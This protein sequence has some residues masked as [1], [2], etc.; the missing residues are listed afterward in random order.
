MLG[1]ELIHV[2]LPGR[3]GNRP[4]EIGEKAM[5]RVM[6]ETSRD[7]FNLRQP[8]VG[9]RLIRVRCG[10]LAPLVAVAVWKDQSVSFA[11]RLALKHYFYRFGHVGGS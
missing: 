4:T 7:A 2:R 1:Q 11:F 3:T 6:Q 8:R 10:L 5:K 9:T